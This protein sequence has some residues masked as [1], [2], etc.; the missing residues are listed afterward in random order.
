MS[1][2]GCA[3]HRDIAEGTETVVLGIA[4][5]LA[6]G[7]VPNEAAG[8]IVTVE[9]IVDIKTDGYLLD[10]KCFSNFGCIVEAQITL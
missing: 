3:S 10:A 9:D 1:H 5:T 4:L 6:Y 7:V 2:A 8:S